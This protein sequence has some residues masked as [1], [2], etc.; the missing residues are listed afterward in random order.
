M[1]NEKFHVFIGR[2]LTIIIHLISKILCDINIHIIPHTHLD[3]GW[4]KTPEQYYDENEIE[5][6]FDTILSELSDNIQK[7]FVINEIYYFKIWYTSISDKKKE[8]FK[9][10]L[11]DKR[12]EFVSGSYIINDEATPLYY[13][14]IDQI[15]IGNQFLLEEFGILPKTGWYIDSFGHSAGN[16]HILSQM[17]F[18]NLVIGRMHS[19]FLELMKKGEKTEFYWSPYGKNNTNQTILTHVLPLHYGFELY[20][21]ELGLEHEEF[22]ANLQTIFDSFLNKLKE[23]ARGLKHNNILYLFGDDFKYN[24]NNLFLNMDTLIEIFKGLNRD[25]MPYE[26]IKMEFKTIE[27]I[28]IF[29]STPEKYFDYVQKELIQKNKELD[30]YTNIDFYPLRSDCFWTGYFTSRPY[31]KGYIRKSSNIFYTFSK[32]HSF[33]LLLN[34]EQSNQLILSNLNNLRE[35]VGLTQH[36]DSITGTCMQ[37]VASDYI[38]R[39]MNNI[40]K[41]EQDFKQSIKKK[42]NIQIGKI[43]YNNY[44]S[45]E[46]HCSEE[47]FISDYTTEK[48]LIIGIYH[49]KYMNSSSE[50]LINIEIYNSEYEY[51]VKGIK[52]DFF[53]INEKSIKTPEI[54]K[55]KNKCFLNFFHDFKGE[56]SFITLLKTSKIF[57]DKY[58]KF[59]ER[60]REIKELIKADIN[61]Q[62]LTFSPK[63]LLFNLEYF[64]EER[65]INKINFTY[66]DG[67]YYSNAGQCVDGAYIFSPYNKYPEKIKVNYSESFYFKGNLG[68]TFVTR[69]SMSS[70]TIFTIFYNPFF[71]KVEHIFDSL[72][73]SYLLTRFSHSYSFVFKTNINNLDPDNKPIFYTDSNGLEMM[74]RVIDKFEYK[75]TGMPKTG[76]NFYPVTSFISI[77][78][79]N[80]NE[81][82]NKV[83]IFNDRAQGGTGYIPGSIILIL[84]KMSYTND[85]RGLL[86]GIYENESMSNNFKTTHF[87]IFGTNIMKNIGNEENKYMIQKTNLINFIYNYFNTA[88]ILFKVKKT[89]K[90]L[91]KKLVKENNLIND[92]INK[93][94]IVSPDIRANYEL[95]SSNL[96]IGE[97]FRYN[98][99]YF[100]K[101]INKNNDEFFGNI[102]IN[103]DEN[104]KFRI[105]Y[106]KTGIKY[107]RKGDTILL[108]EIKSN[109]KPPKDV[110]LIIDKNEFIYIYF[111]FDN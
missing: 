106:D 25:I 108:D 2:I 45:D 75:E 53:C 80:S 23:S 99:N 107:N 89:E 31:L 3:P 93:Y 46:N 29:Y 83:T 15:R 14:I 34:L 22:I 20:L 59:S 109:L 6:I 21:Q 37:A 86:E 30:T 36:H 4:L 18:D 11:E 103:F 40:E 96:I 64:N 73:K 27:D 42:F 50:L 35:V 52:S 67:I 60:D 39:L 87:I 66:Y 51:V 78:D 84:Q 32:Y 41:A 72:K 100:D 105:Y 77:K 43:C 85:N 74:R 7:T 8:K 54:Y 104:A 26:K 33:N 79:E 61:I 92:L 19:D 95:I 55:Y 56:T 38:N 24:N 111:Y 49:P 68:I 65:Q 44:I 57:K 94:L 10:I 81:N 97:F 69:N 16:A 1:K 28:N 88:T 47:F 91:N 71:I 13:N 63:N 62:K 76:G 110:K 82:K 70:F 102:S 48:E 12:I 90:N 17:N 9:K 101:D 5:V 58:I 98:I